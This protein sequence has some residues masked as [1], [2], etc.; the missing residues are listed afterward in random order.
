MRVCN[1]LSS[2]VF[3]SDGWWKKQTDL[4]NTP[5][6]DLIMAYKTS[7][8]I[9]GEFAWP[10]SEYSSLYQVFERMAREGQHRMAIEDTNSKIVGICT[11]STLQLYRLEIL[12]YFACF[13]CGIRYDDQLDQQPHQRLGEG[14]EC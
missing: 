12:Q 5:I 14:Q 3:A 6:R 4:K 11:Q 10:I 13:V 2:D 1:G 9:N 8:P 7:R